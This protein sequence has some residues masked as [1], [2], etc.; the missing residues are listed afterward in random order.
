MPELLEAMKGRSAKIDRYRELR[1][2][3]ELSFDKF[4]EELRTQI[5][6]IPKLD[7]DELSEA[8]KTVVV[9]LFNNQPDKS[10]KILDSLKETEG[11]FDKQ[12]QSIIDG[13]E[14]AVSQL[15]GSI[16]SIPEADL[17]GIERSIKKIKPTDVSELQRQVKSLS[18]AI[19]ELKAIES[20][21]LDLQPILN[22]INAPRTDAISL[23]FDNHGFPVKA[24]I[25]RNGP[26]AS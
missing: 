3:K 19:S 7:K 1:G 22:A 23:V 10:V 16:S 12:Q 4:T 24:I 25:E 5:Q 18:L 9:E 26:S 14:Q 17:S 21:K 6:D 15:Q 11:Y 2:S 13:L 8:L 20:P